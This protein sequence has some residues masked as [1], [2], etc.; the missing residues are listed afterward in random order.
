MGWLYS[1]NWSDKKALVYHILTDDTWHKPIKHSLKG[2]R[3][4]VAFENTN[5]ECPPERNKYI[6]LFLL[7][8]Q[9][10]YGWGYKDI[11]EDMGP[12][13]YDCPVSFFDIVPDPGSYATEWRNKVR[14]AAADKLIQSKMVK[15]LEVGNNVL[16]NNRR[17]DR[18]RIISLK[19][20]KGIADNGI[21]YRL[22]PS[23][24][25]WVEV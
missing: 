12:C 16:C 7:A 22:K 1:Q 3:L 5:P 19:P 2:N 24:I 6:C 25:S 4:W 9:R 17:P 11:T 13:Y 14:S 10:N 8:S 15:R 18:F 20:L 23:F 21:L